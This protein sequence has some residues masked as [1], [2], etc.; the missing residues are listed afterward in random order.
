MRACRLDDD[1]SP[2]IRRAQRRRLTRIPPAQQ[3]RAPR[4]PPPAPGKSAPTHTS[5]SAPDAHPPRGRRARRNPCNAGLDAAG[6]TPRADTAHT[7]MH[8]SPPVTA[9]PGPAHA[10]APAA[11]CARPAH[12]IS[13]CKCCLY[14]QVCLRL[15]PALMCFLEKRSSRLLRGR[16]VTFRMFA[17]R[18]SGL[19][20][21]S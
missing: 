21:C 11:A 1:R 3:Q 17:V 8:V 16:T 19:G 4:C 14:S 6:L 12:H 7:P 20:F 18:L 13:D 9:R 10:A 5:A 15:L 2:P